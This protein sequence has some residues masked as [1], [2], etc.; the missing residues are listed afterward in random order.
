MIL[1]DTSVLINPPLRWPD[2][3]S[4]SVLT[5]AELE[6]GIERS[7]DVRIRAGRARLLNAY[8][9]AV[10]WIVFD[11]AAARS[12]GVLAA[13]VNESRPAHARSKDILLAAQ[14][15]SLGVPFMT[16]NARDFDLVSHL[17]EIREAV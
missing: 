14:A 9:S 16:R 3:Y 2:T 13:I 17:V 8:R 7:G 11:E 12:Y 15:H 5:L 10:E 4:A 6:F 1:V